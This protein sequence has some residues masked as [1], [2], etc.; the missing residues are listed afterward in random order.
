MARTASKKMPA[1]IG[2]I[3]RAE[4]MNCAYNYISPIK[5]ATF[6]RNARARDY[7]TRWRRVENFPDR[8]E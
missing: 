8:P 6:S 7:R 2:K 5:T 3:G 1:T 4:G